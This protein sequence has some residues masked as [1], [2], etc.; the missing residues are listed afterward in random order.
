VRWKNIAIRPEIDYS[1]KSSSDMKGAKEIR[2]RLRAVRSTAQITWAMQLVASAKRQKAQALA[3]RGRPYCLR[4]AELLRCFSEEA[5]RGISHPFFE[6]REVTHRGIL[7]V[8]T[9]RGLCGSLNTNVFRPV[10]GLENIRW[11]TVGKKAAQCVSRAGGELLASFHVSDRV[12]FSEL[13]PI[14][15]GLAQAYLQKRIDTVEVL[16]PSF[17]NTLLQTPVLQRVLPMRDFQSEFEALLQR[18]RLRPEDFCPDPRE[19]L[20][21]PGIAE[22]LEE[23]SHAF[24]RYQLYQILL[25]AKASEQSA[26]MVA[27]KTATDNAENLSKELNLEYNKVRQTTIT[28][29]IVELSTAQLGM[30]E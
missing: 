19:M 11:M 12:D 23:L 1:G 22:L 18:S 14:G 6:K 2:Q 24:F 13:R 5:L 16:F 27:M 25:E 10:A 9:D 28:N 3:L 17:V 7:L 8:G 29:E 30:E 21:E 20:W 15:E 26:R 4:L